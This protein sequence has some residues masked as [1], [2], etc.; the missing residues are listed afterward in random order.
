MTTVSGTN[1]LTLGLTAAGQS[2]V[3]VASGATISVAGTGASGIY[4][5]PWIAPTIVNLGVVTSANGPAMWLTSGGQVT[6]GST[7]N[8]HALISGSTYGIHFD[9]RGAGTLNNFGTVAATSTASGTGVRFD[10]GGTLVNG[11]NGDTGASISAYTMG[12]FALGSAAS[13]MNY[14]SIVASGSTGLGIYLRAGGTVTNGSA[15]DKTAL[16][17][18]GLEAIKIQ[19]EG[20][21][22]NFGTLLTTYAYP[23]GQIG[24]VSLNDGGAVTN[25]SNT[26]TTAKIAAAGMTAIYIKGAAPS[27]ITNFGTIAQYG[28]GGRTAVYMRN[29]GTITNGSSHDSTARMFSSGGGVI[30]AGGL[31]SEVVNFGTIA[32]VSQ[33]GVSMYAGGTIVNGS[34]GDT[35]ALIAGARGVSLNGLAPSVLTNYGTISVSGS[36]TSTGV[37]MYGGGLVSNG[38]TADRTAVIDGGHA[39]VVMAGESTL[40]NYGTIIGTT[41]VEFS[42]ASGQMKGYSVYGTGTVVDAGVIASS[43]GTSGTA[44]RF[45]TGQER[46]VLDAGATIVGKVVGGYGNNTLE[47]GAGSGTVYGFGKNFTNF[48]TITVDTGGVWTLTGKTNITGVVV[49][50]GGTLIYNGQTITGGTSSYQPPVTSAGTTTISGYA[51]A[52]VALTPSNVELVVTPTGT[53]NVSNNYVAVYGAPGVATTVV[54][55]GMI[56]VTASNGVAFA[57]G[58]T[59]YNGNAF[60][61]NAMIVD[62]NGNGVRFSPLAAGTV[63]NFGTLEGTGTG[64]QTAGI[65]LSDGG[66]VVNGSNADTAALVS[67]YRIGIVAIGRPLALENFGT[68]VSHSTAI[69]SYGMYLRSGGDIVNGSNS[70]RTALIQGYY[71]AI[72]ATVLPTTIANYGKIDAT[73]TVG[74]AGHAIALMQG[75]E[76]VNGSTADTTA[77]ILG[78]NGGAVS[79]GGMVSDAVFNY[80]TI[81]SVSAGSAVQ[82]TPGGT[83]I[84]GALSD[85]VATM[86]GANS[87]VILAGPIASQVLNFGTI[88][89]SGGF[90]VELGA[91]GVLVNGATGDTSALIQGTRAVYAEGINAATIANY[92]TIAEVVAGTAVSL[93]SGGT[94]INGTTA[95]TAALINGQIGIAILNGNGVVLN[96]GTIEGAT[97]VSFYNMKAANG[98]ALT[99]T[100]TVINAGTI[101]STS[102]PGGTAI[103]FGS[104]TER[105]I[106]DPGSVI[107]GK[108]LAGT[109]NDTLELAS[110]AGVGTLS[111]VGHYFYGFD[112]V[113]VDKGATWSLTGNN[114]VASG[115][116]LGNYGSLKASGLFVDAGTVNGPLTMTGG[117]TLSDFGT[118]NGVVTFAGGGTLQMQQGGAISGSVDGGGGSLAIVGGSGTIT[119]LNGA[120]AGTATANG[121]SFAFSDFSSMAI[122]ANA[123][124]NLAGPSEINTAYGFAVLGQLTTA[125]L[126]VSGYGTLAVCGGAG[127][128]QVHG[129]M[130][131]ENATLSVVNGAGIEIGSAGGAAANAV[132]VDA[133]N[134]LAGYGTIA[135]SLIDNGTV[136]VENGM[137]AANKFTATGTLD[138]LAGA[139]LNSTA[140]PRS[141][142]AAPW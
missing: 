18:G 69:S 13:V 100:G 132:T 36:S 35:G 124:W 27:T 125:A 129:G 130:T 120:V 40:V 137:L 44:I 52:A 65:Q 38:S 122:G 127:L 64:Y 106:D 99:G 88:T 54:N 42:H 121:S 9:N 8:D 45:G 136:L 57:V 30:I 5:A 28:T 41:A 104:G 15:S 133:G 11:N 113:V 74:G 140:A 50:G 6:N 142:M 17:R 24:V 56:K 25:G 12:V 46:L 22:A 49:N 138:V 114:T 107:I 115:T 53:L 111:G 102:G 123:S 16:L 4:A 92:G 29:G 3:T 85:T 20:T 119:G 109:G 90:G 43:A 2:Q 86:V 110:G 91:G 59:L 51:T 71:R 101:M 84:N 135:A 128:L 19:G 78:P 98:V 66:S 103:R 81:N 26:D 76:V 96:F 23:S 63:V 126:D 70:D 31:R 55:E 95:D 79:I 14:G 82:L 37:S 80:G 83:V 108:V 77:Y 131:L 62:G 93:T 118:L 67:G 32:G 112:N 105:L 47:L 1:T 21:V 39:G 10:L 33:T 97:G 141:P 94:V 7:S 139:T 73:G 34:V 48:Q 68:V 116:T 61:T 60:Q 89:G 87:G 117:S 134:T 72:V 75:G 58:G